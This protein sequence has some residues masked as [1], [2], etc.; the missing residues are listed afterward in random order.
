[1]ADIRGITGVYFTRAQYYGYGAG[2]GAEISSL[3]A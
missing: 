1:M 3:V 2:A